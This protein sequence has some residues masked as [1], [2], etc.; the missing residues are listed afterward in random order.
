[1]VVIQLLTVDYDVLERAWEPPLPT[2]QPATWVEGRGAGSSCHIAHGPEI[3]AIL[4]EEFGRAGLCLKIFHPL[5]PEE[6]PEFF[7]W[8]GSPIIEAARVQNLFAL[9]DLA[10]M[11]YRIVFLNTCCLAQVV[12]YATGEGKADAHAVQMLIEKYS[13]GTHN[14]RDGKEIFDYRFP[15][16]WVGKWLVDFGG[17]Y[18]KNG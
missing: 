8:T 3:E 7:E 1:M 10:P 13:I 6:N 14:V 17:W 12:E 4:K 18:F 15:C 9:H 5:G 2:D 16:N 11:V